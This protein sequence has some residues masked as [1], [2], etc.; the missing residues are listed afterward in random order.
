MNTQENADVL[1]EL[2]K[3]NK[4]LALIATDGKAHSE[5][6]LLLNQLGFSS[7][8]IGELLAITPN[9]VRLIVHKAKKKNT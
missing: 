9:A 1:A 4:L 2:R 6:I 7:S 5:R 3:M 8:E